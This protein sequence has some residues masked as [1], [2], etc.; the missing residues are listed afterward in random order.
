MPPGERSFLMSKGPREKLTL[1]VSHDTHVLLKAAGA[2]NPTGHAQVVLETWAEN[3]L[4]RNAAALGVGVSKERKRR[5]SEA[6]PVQGKTSN[7]RSV[8]GS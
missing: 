7:G 6:A 2:G 3:Y 4:K 1:L 5:A 8:Q